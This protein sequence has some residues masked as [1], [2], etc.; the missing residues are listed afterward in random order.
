MMFVSLGVGEMDA[1]GGFKRVRELKREK[2][3][4]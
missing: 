1:W 4:W 3:A 2:V